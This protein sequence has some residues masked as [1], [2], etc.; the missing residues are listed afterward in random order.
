MLAPRPLQLFPVSLHV[1]RNREPFGKSGFLVRPVP[2]GWRP[3]RA[4]HNLG[5]A[6][7]ATQEKLGLKRERATM[8]RMP[9]RSMSRV[10]DGDSSRLGAIV[11]LRCV[12]LEIDTFGHRS[13][14]QDIEQ[15]VH[16][17]VGRKK[18]QIYFLS[19][20]L[21]SLARSLPRAKMP[22]P[23]TTFPSKMHPGEEIRTLRV[24]SPV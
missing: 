4:A 22:P 20:A 19:Q 6:D 21:R 14:L 18:G 23:L 2:P 24:G 17:Q 9:V 12:D 16:F 10:S 1:K 15:V 3:V 5:A 11:A 8:E 13:F 7:A